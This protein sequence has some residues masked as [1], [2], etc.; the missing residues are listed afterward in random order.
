[1]SLPWL[2]RLIRSSIGRGGEE[3]G[4]EG[5]LQYR[6]AQARVFQNLVQ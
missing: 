4:S 3:G 5:N 1:M 6:E 2:R